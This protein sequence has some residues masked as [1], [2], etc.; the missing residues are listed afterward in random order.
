MS[1]QAL[2]MKL[3]FGNVGVEFSLGLVVAQTLQISAFD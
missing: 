3:K 2:K 1:F